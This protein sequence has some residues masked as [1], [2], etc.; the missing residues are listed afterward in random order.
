MSEENS[1]SGFGSPYQV[2]VDHCESGGLKFRADEEHKTVFFSVR[3]D[4]AAY[5]IALL[6]THDDEVFQIYVTTP[7]GNSDANLRPLVAEFVARANHRLVIGHFDFDMDDGKLRYHVGHVIGEGMLDD[8]TVGR[9]IGTALST[10]DRYYPALMRVIFGGHTPADA[11]YLAELDYHAEDEEQAPAAPSR[12]AKP[13]AAKPAKAP[14]KKNRRPRKDPR[15][16]TTQELPGL[17]DNQDGKGITAENP[18]PKDDPP[19]SADDA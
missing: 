17:F 8:E 4:A 14:A 7:L 18:L 11:I 3:G 1:S 12:P 5:D 6:I 9:L 16:K 19:P 15:L 10:A 2:V 13:R